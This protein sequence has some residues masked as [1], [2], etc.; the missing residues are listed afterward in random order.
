MPL[1]L[2]IIIAGI[3]LLATGNGIGVFLIAGGIA[4][5]FIIG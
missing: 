1:T 2:I 3:I 4:K 5:H